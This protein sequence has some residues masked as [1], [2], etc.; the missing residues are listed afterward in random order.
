MIAE[1]PSTLAGP[2]PLTNF[3]SVDFSSATVNGKP[4]G[5]FNPENVTM[6]RSGHPLA[7]TSS[8]SGGNAF[9]VTW[10]SST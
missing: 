2:L 4:L 7:A 3:G 10:K 5:D 8:L 6:A 9:S 1:A